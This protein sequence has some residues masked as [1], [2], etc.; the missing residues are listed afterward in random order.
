MASKIKVDQIQTGDGT[1]T[2]ALQNQL[3]GMTH[4]SVPTLTTGH[5]PTL[6]EAQMPAGSVLQVQ[7]FAITTDQSITSTTETTLADWDFTITKVANNSKIICFIKFNA[8]YASSA[9]YWW[10]KAY[11]NGSA[12]TSTAAWK[13][14][15]WTH[16]HL[17]YSFS[18]GAHQQ[19]NAMFYDTT[20]AS[21]V[22]FTFKAQQIAAGS[23]QLWGA[24]SHQFTFMEIKV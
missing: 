13:G 16:S 2:I 4:A 9:T 17:Q 23:L 19:F 21:S 3:S 20:N 5:I 11:A 8:Y 18:A 24:G 6:T 12:V 22:N 1:G 14:N 7:T 10:I 15:I